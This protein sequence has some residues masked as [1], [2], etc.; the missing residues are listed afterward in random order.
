MVYNEEQQKEMSQEFDCILFCG[1]A[2]E[3]G[4]A[5]GLVGTYRLWD[6][7]LMKACIDEVYSK[8]FKADVEQAEQNIK[9]K[10]KSFESEH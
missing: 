3:D 1:N 5:S 10:V 9:K 8:N 7:V 2:G 6:L 4:Y